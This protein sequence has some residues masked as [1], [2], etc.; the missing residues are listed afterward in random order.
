[1]KRKLLPLLAV[2]LSASLFLPSAYADTVPVGALFFDVTGTNLAQFDIVNLTGPNSSLLPD[3]SFPVATPIIFSNLSLTV[4]FAGGGST[5]YGSSYFTDSGDGLSFNGTA[6]STIEAAPNGLLGAIDAT[7][8]GTFAPRDL[9]FNDGTTHQIYAPFSVTI[10]DSPGLADGDFGII[11]ATLTP[12][13]SALI[14]A[15]TGLLGLCLMRRRYL[16]LR[17]ASA[18]GSIRGGKAVVLGVAC[19]FLLASAR[20][21][22]AQSVHLSAWTAP[23]S[24]ASGTTAVNITGSGFPSGTIPAANVTL[25]VAGSCAGSGAAAQVN[26]V[27]KIL[28]TSERVQF[29]IP[30]S[31]ASGTYFV[32]LSGATSTGT[33]FASSNCAEVTVAG[34]APIANLSASSLSFA[35]LAAGTSSP[36]QTVNLTNTGTSALAISSIARTG[37]GANL[38]SESDN[39]APSLAVGSFCTITIGFNPKVPGPYTA[40]ITVTDNASP[41]TQSVALSGTATA[42][43]LTIDTTIATDWKISNGVMNF[44]FN[45]SKQ[46]IFAIHLAGFP[47]NLVDSTSSNMGI[48][49]DNAGNLGA[50]T[51]TP[52]FVNA[53]NYLDWWVTT[54]SNA[55]TNAYTYSMHFVVFPNDPGVHVYFVANHAA[56]DI[57][58][59]IGQVQWVYRS[60]L[61]DFNNTYSVNADLSNPGPVIVP[62]PPA[63]ESFST[64]PGR[65]VQDAT[66]DLHGFPALPVG[67]TRE[68]YTKY[69]YSSYNYLH[70][71]HGTF[72]TTFGTWGYF[73]S[74]ESLVGGPTKQ[75]LI[76]TGNLLILEAYSNHYDNA[77]TLNTPAGTASNRLFGPFY[78]HWNT[79]G[80][81]YTSTGNTLNTPDDMYQDT[82]QAGASLAPLYDNEAQLLAAGYT[83]STARGSV[84][85]QVGNAAA[86]SG[87]APKTAWAVLSDPNKNIQFSSKGYQYWADISSTGTA[88]F[89]GVVPGTYRLSVYILGQWGELRQ[90]G[91]V[92]NAN[93]TTTVPAVSFVPENFG[94]ETVFTIGTPDR[95]SHEFL[96]GHDAQGHDDR[97]FWGAWNYWADFSANNGSVVYNATAGPA[98]P[99]TNDLSKWNYNHWGTFN[100]GL[101]GGVY[102]STDDTT[103]GYKYAIPTYVAGLPGAS[104][105]NGTTTR[106]PAWTV[107]FASPSD[108]GS[109]AFAIVSVALAC[110]EGS[111][112]LDLNGTSSASARTWSFTNASDCAVRSGLSGYTQWVAFRYPISTLKAAGLDN[113]LNIGISQTIGDMDDAIRVELTNTSAAPSTTGWND[114]EYVPTSSTSSIIH[115]NDTVANP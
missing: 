25:T 91:I 95:S 36:T 30:A 49:M 96:H 77:L 56:T 16:Q 33:A 57:A 98:G 29:V 44:D 68:F 104:G 26:S 8:T 115:A 58:G 65:A 69:D 114:Y 92:V 86:L 55:T 81:A 89:T 61:N 76:Y 80:Q 35:D 70:Q 59:S 82:L 43:P 27:I 105:T 21:G 17:P 99:A 22:N 41:A 60:N 9:I 101:Y 19:L 11:N 31:L 54:A 100:P 66:V 113:A 24:G 4:D 106:L 79:F 38:F 18:T 111:Y 52:G 107:H 84:S 1:M 6:L 87:G 45:P 108:V 53:G 20:P 34:A 23:N 73:P 103:D 64:D 71:A 47:D 85:V 88:T 46:R 15:G 14:L 78:I 28:G 48:Y 5:T 83:P 50:G 32:S 90:D 37:S 93:S 12:E 67:Y 97:E 10:A 40:A 42:S 51:T 112:V 94:G 2:I 109:Y 75:N 3:T 39:C 102:V 63:S 62:L 74:N 110:D 7:L 13:P 72:G